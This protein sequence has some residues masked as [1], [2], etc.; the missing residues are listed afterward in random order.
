MFQPP[1]VIFRRYKFLAYNYQT[2]T[3]IFTVVYK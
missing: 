1:W 3:F 2:V